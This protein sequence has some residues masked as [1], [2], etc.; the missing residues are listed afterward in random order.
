M[1]DIARQTRL[2][3]TPLSESAIH[4]I[5]TGRR[6]PSV[7][8]T[9]AVARAC[10]AY[11]DET[12]R[13]LPSS[14]YDGEAWRTRHEQLVP[15]PVKAPVPQTGPTEQLILPTTPLEQQLIIATP[16]PQAEE[17]LE[18][19]RLEGDGR[20]RDAERMLFRE[21]RNG[22]VD[23]KD[24]LAAMYRRQGRRDDYIRALHEAKEAGSSQAAEALER[25]RSRGDT[26][27]RSRR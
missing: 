17:V 16:T 4:E 13:H 14:D 25:F 6:V 1:A 5:V 8:E 7:D 3:G 10:G 11:A 21:A 26:D 22:S 27:P 24:E 9:L 23:A 15:P 18:A 19:R 20:H 2:G 12:G